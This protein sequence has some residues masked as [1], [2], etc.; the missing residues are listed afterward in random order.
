MLDEE[1]YEKGLQTMG[2]IMGDDWLRDSRK[3]HEEAVKNGTAERADF[4]TKILFGYMFNRPQLSMRDRSIVMLTSDIVQNTPNALR[5]HLSV[6]LHSGVTRDE[7]EEIV[8]QLTQYVG[9]P[10]A[11]EAT[12]VIGK[13]F[14]ELDAKKA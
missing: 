2:A 12:I 10:K 6:A 4:S 9:F 8:F 14:A 7:I 13:Y 5:S 11:R 3:R 1:M